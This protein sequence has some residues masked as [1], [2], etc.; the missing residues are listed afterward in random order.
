MHS[1]AVINFDSQLL[2]N[3]R[4]YRRVSHF[5]FSLSSYNQFWDGV[6]GF[7]ASYSLVR[8]Y[9]VVAGELESYLIASS[10][11]ECFC[12]YIPLNIWIHI[13]EGYYHRFISLFLSRSNYFS[14]G[15]LMRPGDRL[16]AVQ[17]LHTVAFL[18]VLHIFRENHSL[19]A[20]TSFFS[21]SLSTS[22][23]S[24]HLVM[25]LSLTLHLHTTALYW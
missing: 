24:L 18:A 14:F 13:K 11:V 12:C 15:R 9:I 22:F 7:F 23:P 10:I 3:E 20:A 6:C 4:W 16:S 17:N 8:L 19:N 2:N 25:F 21:S 1:V 5:S